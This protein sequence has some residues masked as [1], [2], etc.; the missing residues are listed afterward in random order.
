[1]ITVSTE[2]KNLVYDYANELRTVTDCEAAIYKITDNNWA[3]NALVLS[4]IEAVEQRVITKQKLFAKGYTEKQ[5]DEMYCN[6][7]YED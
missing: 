2:V 6:K 3:V 5:I 1:M 7:V 4:L